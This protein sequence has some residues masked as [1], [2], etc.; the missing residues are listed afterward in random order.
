[1]RIKKEITEKISRQ[2]LIS[3]ENYLTKRIR[4]LIFVNQKVKN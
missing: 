2:N 1:M 4:D 3:N